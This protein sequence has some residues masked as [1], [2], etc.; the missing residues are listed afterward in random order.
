MSGGATI[1]RANVHGA[2]ALAVLHATSFSKPWNETDFRILLDQP[3]VAAWM[4]GED[5]PHGFIL[6]R[7]AADE[8]EILTLAVAP[9]HRRAGIA[10]ALVHTACE[11]L[12]AAGVHRL[13]LEV[14]SDNIPAVAL[15][16]AAGFAPCGERPG[17][18]EAA[19]TALARDAVVMARDL[20]R[21]APP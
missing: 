5:L 12:R 13:F 7:A 16:T 6:A 18:Y 4:S 20:L 9:T 17:Y 21:S 15:Y 14:A 19:G 3:G 1:W 2:S 11:E 8:A 10:A